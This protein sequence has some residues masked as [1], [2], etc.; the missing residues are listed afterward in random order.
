MC[1][2]SLYVVENRP[3]ICRADQFNTSDR[4]ISK[5]PI[6]AEA[7][8][9]VFNSVFQNAVSTLALSQQIY[10]LHEVY[11]TGNDGNRSRIDLINE[12]P[13]SISEAY[14]LLKS[15]IPLL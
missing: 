4:C 15:N 5:G 9:E 13:M 10:Q 12:Q 8:G 3:A 1:Y 14:Q 6:D 11:R 2:D 7:Q